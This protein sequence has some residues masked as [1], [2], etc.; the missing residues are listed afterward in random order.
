MKKKLPLIVT[1]M[2]I[3]LFSCKKET[4]ESPEPVP[5]VVNK[6]IVTTTFYSSLGATFEYNADGTLK[7]ILDKRNWGTYQYTFSYQPGKVIITGRNVATN[8]I[9]ETYNVILNAKGYASTCERTIYDNNGNPLYTDNIQYKYNADDLLEQ[10]EEIGDYKIKYVYNSQ[11]ELVKS[12]YYDGAGNL[13]DYTEFQY[14][15]TP[16]RFAAIGPASFSW[17][18]FFLPARNKH[19]VTQSKQVNVV[20]NKVNWDCSF[21]YELDK[22][23]YVKKSIVDNTLPG[24]TDW[25]WIN[26]WNK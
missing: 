9:F 14:G 3:L 23:G 2:S 17:F 11:Q 8:I 12:E 6:K 10:S 16:D 22:D 26:T 13:K 7:L 1:A 25:E 15:T 24:G 18:N 5:V 4:I 19:L 21:T 20:L